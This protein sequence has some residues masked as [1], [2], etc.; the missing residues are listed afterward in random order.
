M[1]ASS[2]LSTDP[3]YMRVRDLVSRRIASGV[4]QVGS[5]LPSEADL[6]RELGVSPG[7]MRRALDLLEEDRV[8]CR[9]QG[10]GVF[11]ADPGSDELATRF[12]N[13]R[14]SNGRRITGHMELMSQTTGPADPTE[15]R[16]LQLEQ[17]EPVVRTSRRRRDETG[18]FMYEEACLAVTRFPGLA[19][20]D[21][22]NYRISALAQRYGVRLGKA[23][24]KVA[25]RRASA[26]AADLLE[27]EPG[28]A[29]LRLERTIHGIDG[30]PVEW[31][32]GL[33]LTR[34]G[35]A[36]AAEMS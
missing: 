13:F 24:E 2:K 18:I 29:L 7:A 23:C 28:T 17:A 20:E 8:L 4:W 26:E 35:I 16:H 12:S 11:V 14:D 3:L 33:C 9:R 6:A 34:D 19:A 31:R 32:V 10:R 5:I 27:V 25:Q 1:A 15:R 21:T 22:G 36:Y 30:L